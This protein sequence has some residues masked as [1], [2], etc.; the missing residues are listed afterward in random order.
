MAVQTG[1]RSRASKW[2][3]I[4]ARLSIAIVLTL[5]IMEVFHLPR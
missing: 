1:I 3:E 5:I 2:R 4:A